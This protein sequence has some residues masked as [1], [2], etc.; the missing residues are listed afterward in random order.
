M[1]YTGKQLDMYFYIIYEQYIYNL[2]TYCIF[3]NSQHSPS[4]AAF[5]DAK[6][7]GGSSDQ[8]WLGV[9]QSRFLWTLSEL[10]TLA[11]ASPWKQGSVR[12]I[13]Q[14]MVQFVG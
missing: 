8:L 11:T 6:V 7:V 1:K 2:H 5:P 10:E 14:T 3:A 13:A 12:T 4:V 9:A